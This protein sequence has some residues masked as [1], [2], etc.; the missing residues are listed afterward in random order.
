MMMTENSAAEVLPG[1]E[2]STER[3]KRR[4]VANL[5]FGAIKA[6]HAAHRTL[7]ERSVD[8]LNEIASSVWFL[9]GHAV[10]F[11]FWLLWN[12]GK[13]G[14]PPV[15][16]PPFGLMTTIVSLEAI[17]LSIFVLMAQQR[18]SAIAE[19]R[20]ELGLQ[21]N[22]RVEQEVTKALQ[23][24]A[25]LYTRLGHRV[26]DD[27]ELHHM[28]QPLDVRAIERDLLEQIEA[29]TSNRH[30]NTM[31]DGAAPHPSIEPRNPVLR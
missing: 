7:L 28:L 25:G 17:F 23:L 22:L 10:G 18:E 31:L 1:V 13:L 2:E 21:V 8:R 5:A 14:I 24:V 3:R 29:A 20:E 27:P 4:Y 11:T 30:H 12:T 26:S 9:V 6:Q 16:P 15:D 19:L